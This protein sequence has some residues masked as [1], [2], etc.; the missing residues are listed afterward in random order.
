[1]QNLLQR[2]L[3]ESDLLEIVLVFAFVCVLVFILCVAICHW[4]KYGDFS[5]HLGRDG[6]NLE[7]KSKSETKQHKPKITNKL[8]RIISNKQINTEDTLNDCEED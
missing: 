2:I 8:Q 4:V 7:I 1:M 5:L 6:L 3:S